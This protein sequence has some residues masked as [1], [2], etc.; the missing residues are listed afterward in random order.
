MKQ[1][2]PNMIARSRGK[3]ELNLN[4]LYVFVRICTI[5][6]L[7]KIIVSKLLYL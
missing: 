3:N 5:A 4:I 6:K 1:Q 7:K 2:M